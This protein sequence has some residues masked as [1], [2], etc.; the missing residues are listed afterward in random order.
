MIRQPGYLPNIGFFKKIQTSDI[1]IYLDDAQ[2]AIRSWDN[3][4]RIRTQKGSS[5]LTVPVTS[6]HGKKLN[7]VKISYDSSWQRKH[8]QA[9]ISSYGKNSFF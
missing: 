1:F 4:N 6:P 5:W 3:R 8:K 7:E 2:F 9:I